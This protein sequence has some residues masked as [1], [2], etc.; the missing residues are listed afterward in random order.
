MD[1]KTP[2]QRYN[3]THRRERSEY[4]K[5]YHW[6]NRERCNQYAREYRQ[7]QKAIVIEHY[8][9]GTNQCKHCGFKDAR[10]LQIDHIEGGGEIHRSK[11]TQYFYTY[12]IKNEFPSG[13]QVLCANCQQIKMHNNNERYKCGRKPKYGKEGFVFE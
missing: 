7:K 13:L 9:N 6:D 12:L 2:Q 1:N 11:I 3:E 4:G 10:T 5:K 8:S